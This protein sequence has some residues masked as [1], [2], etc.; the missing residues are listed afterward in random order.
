MILEAI[1]S[2]EPNAKLKCLGE[3]VYEN[4]TWLPGEYTKPSKQEVLSKVEELKL[5]KQNTE[6]QRLRAREYP[7]ITDYL[8]GIVK[9]DQQQIQTY[10]DACLAVK[11]KYPKP[12]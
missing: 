10:V 1:I 9:G 7:P 6:Y 2:I 4:I 3:E 8:D 11:A 12:E 5:Y